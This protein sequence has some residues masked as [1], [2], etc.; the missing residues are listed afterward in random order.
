[1]VLVGIL[2]PSLTVFFLKNYAINFSCALETRVDLEKYEP[3]DPDAWTVLLKDPCTGSSNR[4]NSLIQTE[5][6]YKGG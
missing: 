4:Q 2:C 6:R 5:K 3:V 1:M